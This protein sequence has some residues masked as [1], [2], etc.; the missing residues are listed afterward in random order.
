MIYPQLL[1]LTCLAT[2]SAVNAKHI[3]LKGVNYVA[4]KGA[5][6]APVEDRCKTQAEIE[7]DLTLLHTMADKFRLL[8]LKDCDQSIKLNNRQI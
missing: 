5:S 6:W 2:L 7:Q 3:K 4:R 8:G 1:K